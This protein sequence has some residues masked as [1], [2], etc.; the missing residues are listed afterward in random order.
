MLITPGGSGKERGLCST[1]EVQSRRIGL[2]PVLHSY[3]K[4][5]SAGS[6]KRKRPARARAYYFSNGSSF[7][8]DFTTRRARRHRELSCFF[9]LSSLLFFTK[10]TDRHAAPTTLTLSNL[11]GCQKKRNEWEITVDRRRLQDAT[12]NQERKVA[13]RS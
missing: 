13:T 5:T 1:Q 11:P 10:T 2:G 8:F 12:F 6:I 7:L 9:F 4:R 3:A